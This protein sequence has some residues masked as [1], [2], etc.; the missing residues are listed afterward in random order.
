VSIRLLIADDEGIERRALRMQL[1][2]AFPGIELLRD[3]ENGLELIDAVRAHRPDIVLADIEM[4][5]M[6]GLDALEQLRQEGVMPHVVI[7]TAY[8]SERYLRRSLSL[9]V[10]AFLEKPIRREEVERTL[11]AL[12]AEVEAERGRDA[13]LAQMRDAIRA[14]RRMVRSELMTN[15]ESDEADPHQI[16]ELLEMLETDA[17]RFLIVTFSLADP[18]GDAQS[19]YR[20]RVVELNAFERLQACVRERGWLPGHIL[21]HRMSCLVPVRIHV[22]R[23]DDYHLRHAVCCEV[24]EVLTAMEGCAA[25]RAGI[26]MSTAVPRALQRSRQQSIQALYRQDRHARLCHY[27]DQPVPLDAENPFLSEEAALLEY[28]QSGNAVQAEACLRRCFAAAPDWTRFETLRNQAFELL[29]ALNRR[30]R[31]Q[32]FEDLLAGVSEDLMR[33]PDRAALEAYVRRACL[34]AIE[35]NN[36]DDSRWQEDIIERAR[37]YIDACYNTEIS[38]ESTAEAIGVSRFYLSRLFKTQLGTNYSAYLAERR[39]HMATLLVDTQRELTNR[40]IAEYVGFRDPDYFGKVF[41]KIVG[42]TITEYRERQRRE[43]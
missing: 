40:D 8:S 4:P 6:N 30:S 16:A 12:I 1:E 3:A 26:G 9:R 7:M 33:C 28:L 37:Q 23:D 25:L 19:I 11:R 39:V 2:K 20:R 38:L 15:I 35:R 41:K 14:V 43:E 18:P 36:R 42:C 5:G 21:N 31:T 34:D 13:E 27:E 32:L 17:R 24:D 10:F 29:L 22:E